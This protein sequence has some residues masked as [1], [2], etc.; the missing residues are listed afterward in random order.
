MKELHVTPDQFCMIKDLELDCYVLGYWD[1]PENIGWNDEKWIKGLEE[2]VG[3]HI[4]DKLVYS[5][6]VKIVVDDM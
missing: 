2:I 1:N 3:K 4:I 5:G 6:T